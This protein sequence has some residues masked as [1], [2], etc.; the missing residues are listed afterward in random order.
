MSSK[1]KSVYWHILGSISFLVIPILISQRPP[2]AQFIS[3]PTFRDILANSI[4]LVIFYINYYLLIPKL[5]FQKKHLGYAVA[6]IIGLLVISL[7]PSLLTGFIRLQ[8]PGPPPFPFRGGNMPVRQDATFFMHIQ[9]NISLYGVIILSS[10]LLRIRTRLFETEGLKQQAEIGSLKSRINPHFLFNTLNNIYALALREKAQATAS[11]L[12]KLS[13]MMR[14][15]VTDTAEE[16]VPLEKEI[17][18]TNDYIELQRMRL[19]ETTQLSYTV[20]GSTQNKKIAPVILMPFIE[21]AFK[22]GVNPNQQA[23]IQ[24]TIAMTGDWL[25]LTVENQKVTPNN[26]PHVK[27]GVGIE[28]TKERLTLLYPKKYSLTINED[29]V[30][31]SVQLILQLA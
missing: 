30:K 27:S 9:H 20:S 28:N 17:N 18:Y 3:E 29:S 19:T 21:N 6:L 2:G 12:L 4:M 1:R 16:F 5:Y 14:Y 25:T 23:N 8:P 31:Y 13:G 10:L 7:L 22:H 15:V 11:S 24:I 26:D